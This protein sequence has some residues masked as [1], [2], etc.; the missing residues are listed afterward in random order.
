MPRMT[1]PDCAVMCNLIKI[2]S[3]THRHTCTHNIKSTT[4]ETSQMKETKT[5]P[6][7]ICNRVAYLDQYIGGLLPSH[8]GDACVRPHEQE[9]RRVRAAAHAVVS[10]AVAAAD[11][12]RDL[13]N[14]RAGHGRHQLCPVLGDPLVLVALPHLCKTGGEGFQEM[15][16]IRGPRAH[17]QRAVCVRATHTL[18]TIGLVDSSLA[19]LQHARIFQTNDDCLSEMRLHTFD[20]DRMLCLEQ[21]LFR[22]GMYNVSGRGLEYVHH[23]P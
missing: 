10:R 19:A 17:Q 9:P 21:E 7:P 1:G 13:G 12:A 6:R 2:H 11:D 5:A 23:F 16:G 3:H 14:L 8:D 15:L 18:N 4:I 20:P 22:R